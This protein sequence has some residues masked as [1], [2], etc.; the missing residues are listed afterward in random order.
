VYY[1]HWQSL[2]PDGG[3][4]FPVFQEVAARLARFHGQA[5]VWMR[6]TEIAAYR[7]TERHTEV[8]PGEEGRSFRLRIP[9]E[10]LHPLTFRIAGASD[11]K[12]RTPRGQVL[13]PA[14]RWA[15]GL[16]FDLLPESGRYEFV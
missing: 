5:I 6:P 9:F 1:G 2:R 8:R 3:I 14:G 11:V 12:I 4:G 15:C 13:S 16:L 10:A 7:H